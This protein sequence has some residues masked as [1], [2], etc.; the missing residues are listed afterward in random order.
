MNV[1]I[2][3]STS[4]PPWPDLFD[5]CPVQHFTATFSRCRKS[6]I[7][8][9]LPVAGLVPATHVLEEG[10]VERREAVDDQDKPGQGGLELFSGRC[11]QP[12]SGSA[13]YRSYTK[14]RGRPAQS[15]VTLGRTWSGHPRLRTWP[16]RRLGRR[17]LPSRSRPWG[18]PV[19]S[20]A[21]Q[22]THFAQPESHGPSPAKGILG[23]IERATND[24]RHFN[25][26]T[27]RRV[28]P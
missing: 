8:P 5:G 24:R 11:E 19:V 16:S 7:Q 12:I 18:S 21:P 27:R 20:S 15:L 23:C 2:P 17:G 1:P 10:R 25:R 6:S 14:V 9:K 22:T 3:H 26:T 4:S 13:F 28:R